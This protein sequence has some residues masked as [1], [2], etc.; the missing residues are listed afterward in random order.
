MTHKVGVRKT[1]LAPLFAMRKEGYN[2]VF[3]LRKQGFP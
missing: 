3:A 1:A 2:L